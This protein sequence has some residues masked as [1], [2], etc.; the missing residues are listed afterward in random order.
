MKIHEEWLF[1]SN[2]DFEGAQFLVTTR[3]NDICIYHTQ[4]AAE[5]ALKGYL[6]Y[7]GSLPPKSHD[8]DKLLDLCKNYDASFIDIDLQ[9][10][11]LNGM[12][13]R[14]RY[15]GPDLMP[16]DS[17]VKDA[18]NWAKEVLDFVKSKCI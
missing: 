7:K 11:E 6:V 13:V 16:S 1:K 3:L 14:F 5:K 18:L 4:Q 8:L 9:V 15:P 12:D 2:N 17:D 10:F